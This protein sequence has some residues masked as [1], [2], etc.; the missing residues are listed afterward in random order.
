MAIEH[1]N[2]SMA[3]IS[4]AVDNSISHFHVAWRNCGPFHYLEAGIA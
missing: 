2:S 4:E 3:A 1:V